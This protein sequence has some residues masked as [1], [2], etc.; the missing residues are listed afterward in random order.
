M[1]LSKTQGRDI[2]A[3]YSAGANGEEMISKNNLIPQ[4]GESFPYLYFEQYRFIQ[5]VW[6]L[7]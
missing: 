2:L 3:T 7:Y 6:D 4:Q 5:G 1:M